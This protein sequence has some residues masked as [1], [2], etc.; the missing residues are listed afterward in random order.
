MAKFVLPHALGNAAAT[1]VFS[2]CGTLDAQ[3]QHVLRHPAFVARDVRS[4]A[5][6]KALLAQQ[7][8]A[9]V[10]RS[11]RPDLARLREMHDVLRL[12]ARP[13]H[14]LLA[15]PRAARPRE[16]MHGTTRF[17]SL[18][19][20]A[21]TG[22]PMRAMMRMFTTT[23]GESVSCT[24]MLRHRRTHRPHAERQHIHR[25]APHAAAKQLLQLATHH[26]RIFPVVGRPG[27]VLRQRADERP[28]LHARHIVRHRSAHSSIPATVPRFSLMKVPPSPAGRRESRTLP[29]S[30]P[31]SGSQPGGTNRPSSPPSESGACWLSKFCRREFD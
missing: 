28:V 2:P 16:C 10:A 1:Y 17:S 29:A 6:R 18:S 22:S 25:A 21:N 31:P 19:I 8:I 4:N 7:R 5:Q 20:S 15:R 13:R 9:A 12:V 27:G 26:I 30:R 11:V 23:Y 14:I 24:P 3:D